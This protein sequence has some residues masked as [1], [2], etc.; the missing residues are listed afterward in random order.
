MKSSKRLIGLLVFLAIA[1][2]LGA[3]WVLAHDSNTT[4][5]ACVNNSSGTIFIVSP[6]EPCKANETKIVWNSIGPQGPPGPEGPPGP[7]GPQGEQG[8]CSCDIS[9]AEFDALVARVEGLEQPI[10]CTTPAD[11]PVDGTPVCSEPN[12]CQGHHLEATCIAGT[13][14]T[15]SVDNDSA[16][17]ASVLANDCGY[18]LPIYCNGLEDQSEPICPTSCT[19]DDDCDPVAY[20]GPGAIC[21]PGIP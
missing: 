17:D 18:F 9:R 2:A 20:C 13:C 6:D 7:A 21:V 4:Y 16:C 19:S 3:T 8:E 14:G 12:T 15:T 10:E 5:Y 1:A 11:C